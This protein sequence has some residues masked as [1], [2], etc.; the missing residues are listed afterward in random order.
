M[1][2]LSLSVQYEDL[3]LR[4]YKETWDYQDTVFRRIIE[5]KLASEERKQDIPGRLIFVEHPHVYTLGKS[6]SEDNLLAELYS[7]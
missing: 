6:G 4:D 3:G 1:N 2:T 7:A 5:N